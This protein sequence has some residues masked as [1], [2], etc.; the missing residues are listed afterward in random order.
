MND[1]NYLVI[2]MQNLQININFIANYYEYV[3]L[4]NINDRL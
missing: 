4:H 2:N 1:L 3:I